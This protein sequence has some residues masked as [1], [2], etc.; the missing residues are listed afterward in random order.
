MPP[1]QGLVAPNGGLA[2]NVSDLLRPIHK[3]KALRNVRMLRRGVFST[4]YG[5]WSRQRAG[6]FNSGGALLGFGDFSD[7]AGTHTLILQSGSKIYSYNINTNTETQITGGG[8]GSLSSSAP[9][10]MRMFAPGSSGAPFMI[11]CNGVQEAQKITNLTTGAVLNLNGASPGATGAPLPVK[12]YSEPLFCEP[13]RDRMIFGGWQGSNTNTSRDIVITNSGTAD[14][15]TQSSPIVATDGGV[16]T[17]PGGLG[18]PI[19]AKCVR[20]SNQS[21]DQVV[22]I[23]CTNG[24]ALITGND[25]TNFQ[26]GVLTDE[27][28]LLSNRC[29]VVVQNDIYMLTTSGIR[30]LSGIANGNTL[31]TASLTRELNDII[32]GINSAQ[33]A[34]AFACHHPTTQEIEW[35]FPAAASA[36][37]NMALVMNYNTDATSYEAVEP[38]WYTR[39][40]TTVASMIDFKGVQYGGGY[41][42]L[43]QIHN[44]LTNLY[45]TTPVPFEITTAYLSSQNLMMQLIM[46]QVLAITEGSNQNFLLNMWCFEDMGGGAPISRNQVLTNYPMQALA[47]PAT[48]LNAWT[49]GTNAFPSNF[50]KLLEAHPKGSGR[51]WE[52]QIIGNLSTHNVDFVGWQ[53]EG[54]PVIAKP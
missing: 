15:C 26:I 5:G 18:A 49:L 42:G 16:F 51:L 4:G 54:N 39:D 25:A 30:R 45:D 14:V 27:F 19:G 11:Y 41:D 36:Q 13:F 12:T 53:Y 1:V 17:L 48:V 46:D 47:P 6:A 32:I 21:S 29:M 2:S 10:C 33:G 23:G 43:L 3:A 50:M 22:L 7:A 44:T 38:I 37:S 35:W 31:L 52:A 24:F 9:P 28:G 40:S 20:V 34:Q 8:I